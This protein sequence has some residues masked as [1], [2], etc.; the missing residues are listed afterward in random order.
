MGAIKL[1]TE[2]S[3]RKIQINT[4]TYEKDY[5]LNLSQMMAMDTSEEFLYNRIDSDSHKG[6]DAIPGDIINQMISFYLDKNQIKNAMYIICSVNWG[7][8]FSDTSRVRFCHLFDS[9]GNLKIKWV[10]PD[11]EQK[12]GKHNVYFNNKSVGE[13]LKLYL[14]KNPNK[15][16]YD[17]LF[18]SDSAN[19]KYKSL[20]DVE[21]DELYGCKLRL[22]EK[23]LDR[24]QKEKKGLL[25]L[26]SSGKITED[27]FTLM[28]ADLENDYTECSKNVDQLK[29]SITEYKSNNPNAEK[30]RVAEPIAS[31][32]AERIIKNALTGIGINVRNSV[33]KA[34]I[35]LDKQFNT[36]SLRKTFAEMF[37]IRGC[38]LNEMGILVLNPTMLSLVQHKFMHSNNSTTQR[39]NKQEENAFEIICTHLNLGLDA[40]ENFI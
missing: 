33:D 34:E 26:Y 40:L 20:K 23:K 30:I 5:S 11:G 36:H 16:P 14:S 8:R 29:K 35:N 17:Y 15:R 9:K 25:K 1:D 32:S 31:K 19:V 37:Y 27:D 2:I 3:N 10:L 39:Y 4:S 22:G 21:A 24:I 7:T 38:E 13:I 12:T 28:Y 18:T 6:M